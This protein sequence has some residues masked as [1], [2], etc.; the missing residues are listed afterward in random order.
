ML[1]TTGWRAAWLALLPG[2]AAAGTIAYDSTAHYWTLRSSGVEY[3]LRQTGEGVSLDYFG[4]AGKPAWPK[5]GMESAPAYEI[6][7]W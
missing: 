4:P 3:R 6:W 5:S 1:L 2:L 7:A